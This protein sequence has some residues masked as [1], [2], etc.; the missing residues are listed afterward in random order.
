MH[1]TVQRKRIGEVLVENG[2][3]P[4]SV[5]VQ[6]LQ[7]QGATGRRLGQIL[8]DMGFI[9]ED[10]ISRV[11]A[12][13]FQFRQA[14]DLSSHSVSP[15]VL[16]L[17]PCSLALEKLIFPFAC[18]KQQLHLAMV[19]PL[20]LETIDKV[21][22]F[23]EF[24]VVPWVAT[25]KVIH[26]A[27]RHHYFKSKELPQT[28]EWQ[29]L[30][31]EHKEMVRA[32]AAA[33]LQKAGFKVLLAADGIE[34]LSL[35]LS[36]NPHLIVLETALPRMDGFQVFKSLQTNCCTRHIPVIGFSS[37]ASVE[38][39]DRLLEMGF[40]DLLPQPLHPELL[41]ARVR[42]ALRSHYGGL[43]LEERRAELVSGNGH[44]NRSRGA[45]GCAPVENLLKAIDELLRYNNYLPSPSSG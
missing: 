44:E 27:I 5:L 43:P 30:I 24:E 6:A 12:Q 23:N 17:V 32:T 45:A 25:S 13:Q 20:D 26:D 39:E 4:H 3:I 21:R 15:K 40:F 35:V 8:E 1:P 29:I 14:R 33:A 16:E 9:R 28:T 37:Q 19:D 41:L 22:F 10:D 18:D 31:V 2:L 7:L 34:A 42:R 38:E 11:L 36:A